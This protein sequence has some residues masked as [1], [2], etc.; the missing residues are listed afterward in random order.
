MEVVRFTGHQV[1]D[2]ANLLMEAAKDDNGRVRLE[3]IVAA[4]WL[5]K[6]KGLPIVMEA[7]KKPLDQWMAG[8]Y[9]T[10]VAHLN[11]H[12]VIEKKEE[13]IKDKPG[14]IKGDVL[15]AGKEIYLREGYCVTCHQPDGK[16]LEASGFP[17]LTGS[18][19]VVGNE[20]RLI[21]LVLKGLSWAH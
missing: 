2:Q 3:A 12:G 18:Q 7:G 16:G 4:S 21:K 19:W 10:S 9:E 6:E 20:E 11:G 13:T 8:A 1:A 5:D 15:L 17:P 14:G